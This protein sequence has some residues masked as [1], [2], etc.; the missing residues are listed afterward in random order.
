MPWCV[1]PKEEKGAGKK[2]ENESH[3]TA[4]CWMSPINGLNES[5]GKTNTVQYIA[6]QHQPS[7]EIAF[8]FLSHNTSQHKKTSQNEKWVP[9]MAEFLDANRRQPSERLHWQ[10]LCRTMVTQNMSTLRLCCLLS[11]ICDHLLWVPHTLGQ[12]TTIRDCSQHHWGQVSSP[13]HVS[14]WSSSNAHS[15]LW[16]F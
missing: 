16:T 15:A 8:V 9:H 2:M 11:R 12:Q 7:V 10:Q 5:H 1:F 3:C 14:L 13:F 4:A 6:S